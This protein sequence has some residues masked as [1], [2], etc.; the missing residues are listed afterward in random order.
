[1]ETFISRLPQPRNLTLIGTSI[2]TTIAFVTITKY[3]FYSSP[4]KVIPSPRETVLS[5]LSKKEQD[6]L[7]YP[8]D[9]FPGARD[10]S[11]P[12]RCYMI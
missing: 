2:A 10:V 4:P 3:A 1:M 12:V 5:R 11:S 9:V 8:P 7:P 6:A